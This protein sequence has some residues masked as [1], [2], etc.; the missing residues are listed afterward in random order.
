MVRRLAWKCRRRPPAQRE[1]RDNQYC[2]SNN[3]ADGWRAG[4]RREGYR[5]EALGGHRGPP[6]SVGFGKR[7]AGLESARM[8]GIGARKTNSQQQFFNNKLLNIV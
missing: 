2:I 8:R 6:Q 3:K 4:R 5:W 1:I 7:R